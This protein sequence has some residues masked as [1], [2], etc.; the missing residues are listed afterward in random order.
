MKLRQIVFVFLVL[1]RG[2]VAAQQS[3][4][5]V[6]PNTRDNLRLQQAIQ[7]MDSQEELQLLSRARS[8]GCVVRRKVAATEAV[9]SWTD[10]AEPSVMVR[11]GAPESAIRYLMSRLGR[12]ANQK[13]VVYFHP[14][15]HGRARLYMIQH[16]LDFNFRQI[17]NNLEDFGITSRTVVP[18]RHG[19][20]IY[21]IDVDNK[22]GDKVREVAKRFHQRVLSQTGNAAFI[23]DDSSREKA[24]Q[25]FAEEIK[26]YEL[27][28]PKLPPPCEGKP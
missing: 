4:G 25:V 13:A 8:L 26:Q 23:G 18:A 20:I 7:G 22:L 11:V 12:D 27:K 17:G 15:P 6:S 5:F 1:S 10:G 24:Q 9:G 14:A 21:I 2:A 19:K 28:H 3:T 16:I